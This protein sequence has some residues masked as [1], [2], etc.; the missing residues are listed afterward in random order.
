MSKTYV[1]DTNVLLTDADSIF[2]FEEN[3]II[4]PI[5]VIE[6]L[7]KFKKNTGSLG[8]NARKVIKLLD[9]LSLEGSLVD[10]VKIGAGVLKIGYEDSEHL[11]DTTHVDNDILKYIQKINHGAI[12]VTRDANLRVKAHILGISAQN[13]KG[14]NYIDKDNFD[15]GYDKM[16]VSAQDIE[17]LENDSVLVLKKS[18]VDFELY[19]NKYLHLIDMDNGL[20]RYGRVSSVYDEESEL[21]TVLFVGMHFP[22]H[23]SKIYPKNIEQ[24]FLM[25]ALLNPEI[26]LVSVAGPA[27]TG[28]TLLSTGASYYMVTEN[29]STYMYDKLLVS[30]P[31]VPMGNDIGFLPGDLKEKLDPWVTPIY[32]SLEFMLGKEGKRTAFN[33]HLVEIEPLTY[34]RGRS[35]PHNILLIDEAQNLNSLEIKTII[36]RVGKGTKI[37][38]TGDVDQIDNPYVDKYSNGLTCAIN[39]FKSSSISAHIVMK[40]GVRSKLAEEATKRL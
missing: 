18:L 36:T 6:E 25:D 1:L 39:A 2:K 22:G 38:L 19:P 14:D 27:G 29:K 9:S 40:E 7:D 8:Y 23:L 37:I 33:N 4:I 12:L 5:G 13:Y 30:R 32:D 10:G 34:I 3:I 11:F 21:F 16:Y 28:K 31:I 24:K 17:S 15:N 35:I 26:H 20:E